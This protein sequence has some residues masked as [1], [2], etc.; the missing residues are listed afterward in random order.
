MDRQL[1]K[2]Q[3]EQ[4]FEP[5]VL[6]T[7]EKLKAK[8]RKS[9]SKP[10][11]PPSSML[12]NDPMYI[13]MDRDFAMQEALHPPGPMKIDSVKHYH[14]SLD[15][16]KIQDSEVIAFDAQPSTSTKGSTGTKGK[17]KGKTLK[18][19]SKGKGKLQFNDIS[20]PPALKSKGAGKGRGKSFPGLQWGGGGEKS[21][22]P[23]PSIKVRAKG[24]AQKT[25]LHLASGAIAEVQT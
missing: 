5:A 3:P 9:K 2:L 11:P 21:F 25:E 14:R 13:Q 4:S 16:S 6:S 17:Q 15:P 19:K 8:N 20:P 24:R 10:K 7:F 22:W 23:P 18:G 12:P 1:G